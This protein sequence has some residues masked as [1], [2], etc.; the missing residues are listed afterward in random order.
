MW[1]SGSEHLPACPTTILPWGITS[2]CNCPAHRRSQELLL[3][4][5]TGLPRCD[6]H[7]L[8]ICHYCPHL[9]SDLRGALSGVQ[10]LQ[11]WP[12]AAEPSQ[13]RPCHPS[14]SCRVVRA[15]HHRPHPTTGYSATGG[16][17]PCTAGIESP[18]QGSIDKQEKIPDQTRGDRSLHHD[19]VLGTRLGVRLLPG[20]AETCSFADLQPTLVQVQDRNADGQEEG[21]RG[22]G[23]QGST[24]SGGTT[25]GRLLKGTFSC[26]G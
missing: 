13:W 20:R 19:P 14:S 5:T 23:A 17:S 8:Q 25:L 26:E 16:R 2:L 22:C 7:L 1:N 24:S 10:V 21:M 18:S 6:H 9:C 15:T 3:K 12:A 4:V 11:V